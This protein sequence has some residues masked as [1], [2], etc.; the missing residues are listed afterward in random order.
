M[1]F[2]VS[3]NAQIKEA[4]NAKHKHPSNTH[5]L[6][7]VSQRTPR[8]HGEGSVAQMEELSAKGQDQIGKLR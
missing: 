4:T 8:I 6:P 7:R 2:R 3:V 5:C 1:V